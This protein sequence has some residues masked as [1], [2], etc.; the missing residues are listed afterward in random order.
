MAEENNMENL[1]KKEQRFLREWEIQNKGPKNSF[2]ILNAIIF[3][4]M[5]YLF[6]IAISYFA[7]EFRIKHFEY[8]LGIIAIV[9]IGIL[10][11]F[12][13]Y[14]RSQ[15]RYLSIKLKEKGSLNN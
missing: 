3:S 13:M 8:Y 10:I 6:G 12:V 14:H 15:S 4:V 2:I 9:V 11:A 7:S 1:T 5:I